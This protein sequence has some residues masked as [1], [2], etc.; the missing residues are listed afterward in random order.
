MPHSTPQ[1]RLIRAAQAVLDGA[2]YATQIV[3]SAIVGT[4]RVPPELLAELRKAVEGTQ[5][6]KMSPH[7]KLTDPEYYAL[8]GARG[9]RRGGLATGPQKEA[10]GRLGGLAGR[11][12]KKPRKWR[13][14]GPFVCPCGERTE[15]LREAIHQKRIG[16]F[17]RNRPVSWA[18]CAR[19]HEPVGPFVYDEDLEV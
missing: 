12:K 8:I 11:G 1:S 5:P 4:Q 15:N 7:A 19:C 17:V 10:S 16:G 6:T 2:Y 3:G 18:E 14:T 9:G 13:R